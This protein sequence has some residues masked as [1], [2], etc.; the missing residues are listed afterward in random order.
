L[1][2]TDDFDEAYVA[3]EEED[4]FL[5]FV[6]GEAAR[7]ELC[8]AAA[9]RCLGV[10]ASAALD[11]WDAARRV[12]IGVR[13]PDQ[14]RGL[15]EATRS[16]LVLNSTSWSGGAISTDGGWVVILNPLHDHV[17]QRAT[18]AEELT[19]IV[20]GHPPST[21]DPIT[22]KRSYRDDCE[23]EAYAVG[24][25][26]LLPYSHL[27]RT[28]FIG[29]PDLARQ[30]RSSAFGDSGALQRVGTVRGVSDQP[31]RVAPHVRAGVRVVSAGELEV[32]LPRDRSLLDA[33]AS[34]PADAMRPRSRWPCGPYSAARTRR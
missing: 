5:P 14:V 26:M 28:P 31:L 20:M 33:Q 8:A 34:A 24:G 32:A 11:P 21:I 10:A 12:H 18:L 16:S 30:A 25:A 23:E 13:A 1:T 17:R 2:L 6:G 4:H 22:G 9:K 3:V 29:P 7:I 15:D 19:H 27:D